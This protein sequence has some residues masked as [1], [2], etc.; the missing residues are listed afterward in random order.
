MSWN[1]P[2]VGC[3]V[4]VDVVIRLS[5]AIRGA[6]CV[7]ALSKNRKPIAIA[8]WINLATPAAGLTLAIA[9]NDTP[10]ITVCWLVILEQ[11]RVGRLIVQLSIIDV[12]L[13][14]R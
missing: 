11:S 7:L 5:I 12:E 4:G 10:V 3:N 9:H 14:A 13:M 6:I 2:F 1:Y 8:I